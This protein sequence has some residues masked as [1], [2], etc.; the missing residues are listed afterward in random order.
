MKKI[1]FKQIIKILPAL[2]GNGYESWELRFLYAES[3]VRKVISVQA[4][5]DLQMMR[6]TFPMDSGTGRGRIWLKRSELS[7][8]DNK[9]IADFI[10][11]IEQLHGIAGL[12]AL[13]SLPAHK[14]IVESIGA[15]EFFESLFVI[16]EKRHKSHI[17]D[18]PE[19]LAQESNNP[20]AS[21]DTRARRAKHDG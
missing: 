5:E 3:E 17:Y 11:V 19:Y 13:V 10:G 6:L 20:Y 8:I 16:I 14:L 15:T 7:P 21:G 12:D 2:R 1:T 9:D 18:G 4:D